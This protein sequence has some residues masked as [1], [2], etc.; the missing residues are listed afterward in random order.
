M[1][2]LCPG[3]WQVRAAIL[4]NLSAPPVIASRTAAFAVAFP[5]SRGPFLAAKVT[6]SADVA[7]HFVDST[8]TDF[9][10]SARE[11]PRRRQ[12]AQG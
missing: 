8:G 9:P 2:R 3:R 1:A 10:F 11:P 12:A 7:R 4:V 5:R 6:T